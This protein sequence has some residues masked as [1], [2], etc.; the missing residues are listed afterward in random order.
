[1]TNLRL[2]K[3]LHQFKAVQPSPTWLAA[4]RA[5][6]M[7]QI[8]AQVAE[9]EIDTIKHRVRM[10][11]WSIEAAFTGAVSGMAGRGAAVAALFV[12][13]TLGG[14]GYVLAA[15]DS[16][17]PGDT[18]YPVKLAVED[19]RLKTARTQKARVAL[20][21]EFASRRLHE[22]QQLATRPDQG[23][24]HATVLVAQFQDNLTKVSSATSELSLQ[25]PDDSGEVAMLFDEKL[26]DYKH[27]LSN[28]SSAN[29]E[30]QKE[31]RKAIS[32]VSRAQTQTLKVIVENDEQPA[33]IV[34]EKISDKIRVAE[35][36]LRIADEKLADEAV[37][38]GAGTKTSTPT[39]R[40][41]SAIA[42][43][44]LAEARQKIS[45]GD[46]RAAVGIIDQIE[47]IVYEVEEAVSEQVS[48][49]VQGATDSNESTENTSTNVE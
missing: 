8:E 5:V 36:S 28:T 16:S 48:G 42:K 11:V 25:S 41:Q 3:Q 40:E 17:I 9:R 38:S 7:T 44:N 19:M 29:P 39:V 12:A 22:V 10:F 2:K 27:T 14:S 31:L 23:V 1:M 13:L 46:Y 24:A 15:A 35:E 26:S 33:D 47:D 20:E 45:E 34:V 37:I 30:L 43:V 21:V 6:L 4:R 32:S 18:L 49:E